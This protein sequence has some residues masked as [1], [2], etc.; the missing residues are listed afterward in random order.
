MPEGVCLS[1]ASAEAVSDVPNDDT[2]SKTADNAEMI[3]FKV[4]GSFPFV[5]AYMIHRQSYMND[6]ITLTEH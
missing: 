3:F 4:D 2:A 6:R 1:A 5:Y